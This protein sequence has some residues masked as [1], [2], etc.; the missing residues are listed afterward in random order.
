MTDSRL[1]LRLP[2]ARQGV[3]LKEGLDERRDKLARMVGPRRWVGTGVPGRR[4]GGKAHE[5]VDCQR[6]QVAG[7]SVGLVRRRVWR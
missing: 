5:L 2:E 6:S 7:W 3:A 1:T 4:R